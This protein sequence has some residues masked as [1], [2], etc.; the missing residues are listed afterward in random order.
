MFFEKA[1]VKNKILIKKILFLILP[2]IILIT[3]IKTAGSWSDVV[4]SGGIK[5]LQ[6]ILKA[7][8]APDLSKSI[9]LIALDAAIKTLAYAIAGLSLALVLAFVFGTLASGVILKP[10][11]RKSIIIIFFRFLLSGMRSIH[12]LI[13]AWFFVAAMGFSPFSAI[14][15]IA[16]S[17]GGTLGR[18]FADMLNDVPQNPLEG[19]KSSGAT[20]LQLFIYGFL[21]SSVPNMLSYTLY[22]LECAVRSSAI[23]SFVGLG[24]LG[25]QIH[26]SLNDLEYNEV[27]TFIYFLIGLVVLIEV[28]SNSIRGKRFKYFKSIFFMGVILAWLYIFKYEGANLFN[29]FS[30]KNLF[31]TKKF[32]SR[33]FNVFGEDSAFR[34]SSVIKNI[35]FLTWETLKMS[36]LAI[37]ISTSFMFMVVIRGAKNISTENIKSRNS[38]ISRGIFMLIRGTYIITRAIPELIWA[39]L[40]VFV[41]KPGIITGA[42]ALAIHNFGV[43]GKLCSEVIEEMDIRPIKNLS[44]SGASRGQILIYGVIPSVMT[45]FITYI[46]YRWEV[47]I[48]STIIVGFVGAGGLGQQFKLSMSFFRYTEITL[49]VLCYLFLVLLSDLIC[50]Y[51]KKAATS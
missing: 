37:C 17:Y 22:R 14:F 10:S 2:V 36:I 44:L 8:I 3:S 6:E 9:V 21:P 29:F 39:T 15:A 18:I 47:I 23:M 46:L 26:L 30:S 4:H 24:G 7:G 16:I 5:T 27:W 43:L 25:Y 35:L 32:L 34:D 38:W 50:A 40:I 49:I 33:V 20:R 28:M 41:L 31:Y 12:E 1:S 51:L 42:L 45:R 48:R 19:L 11:S 13:W